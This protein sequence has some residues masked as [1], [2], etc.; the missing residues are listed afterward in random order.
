MRIMSNP[1]SADQCIGAS[2]YTLR[3]DRRQMH[4]PAKYGET[5]NGE[6]DI[7]G[8]YTPHGEGGYSHYQEWPVTSHIDYHY[9]TSR[10]VSAEGPYQGWH[11]M[12]K[13]IDK[14]AEFFV[15]DYRRAQAPSMH[16]N[17]TVYWNPDVVLDDNGEAI[18][19]FEGNT[20]CKRLAVSAEGITPDGQPMVYRQ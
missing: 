11:L 9:D 5:I 12:V 3:P 2:I 19:E 13:G 15:G 18:V 1:L 17:R 16:G 7:T 4:M 14:P 20:T 8:W 6:D 10:K